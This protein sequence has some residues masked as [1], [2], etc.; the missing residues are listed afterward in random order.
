MPIA[1]PRLWAHMLDKILI[2]VLGGSIGT[3]SRYFLAEWGQA[4]WGTFFPYGTLLVN[5]AGCLIMGC[6]LGFF[7]SRYG[8][9]TEAPYPLRLLC[10]TGFLGAL[11]TFSSYELEALL[12]FRH[13]AWE[14]ALIYLA[15]S[16]MLGLLLMLCG[17]RGTRFLLSWLH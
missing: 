8:A 9:L 5:L 13:G 14:R 17:F 2:L 4:R 16:I 10:I 15:G 6:L 11:T 7:E 1:C 3:L 12:M